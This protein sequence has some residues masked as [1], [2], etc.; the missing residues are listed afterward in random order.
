MIDKD[1]E[2]AYSYFLRKSKIG[3]VRIRAFCLHGH[4]YLVWL[5]YGEI[6]WLSTGESSTLSW[7]KQAIQKIYKKYS[8][9]EAAHPPSLRFY[10]HGA[11]PHARLF[12]VPQNNP[13]ALFLYPPLVKSP[14]SASLRVIFIRMNR[15]P[16]TI[17]LTLPSK[18]RRIDA[19]IIVYTFP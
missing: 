1:S 17:P 3:F 19:A 8:L 2:I 12:L 5:S 6:T 9:C 15:F 13:A 11:N 18:Q 14:P 16:L 7:N 10:R 4:W